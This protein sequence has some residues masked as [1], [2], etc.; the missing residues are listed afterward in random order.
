VR[1][2]TDRPP[3]HVDRRRGG[4]R[5]GWLLRPP[6]LAGAAVALLSWWWSLDPSMLPRSWYAQG[7]VSG[8]SGPSAT[9][10]AASRPRGARRRAWLALGVVAAVLVVAGSDGALFTG[11][12]ASNRIWD[13]LTDAREAGSPSTPPWR[14]SGGGRSGPTGRRATT[15]PPGPAGTRW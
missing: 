2:E 8:L 14:R 9:C 3:D 11:P 12:T 13:Q 7:A 4:A 1:Q 5:G 15:S 6:T 10:S